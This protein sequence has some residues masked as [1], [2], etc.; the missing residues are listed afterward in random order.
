MYITTIA[1]LARSLSV[2]VKNYEAAKATFLTDLDKAPA[3]AL[4]WSEPLHQHAARYA[5]ATHYLGI[6]KDREEDLAESREVVDEQV[7]LHNVR[8]H[9]LRNAINGALYSGSSSSP[10]S[11]LS[12]RYETTAWAELAALFDQIDRQVGFGEKR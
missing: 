4:A 1:D 2:W 9:A 3:N 6:I 12:K 10:L 11:N 7:A 8:T 5:L